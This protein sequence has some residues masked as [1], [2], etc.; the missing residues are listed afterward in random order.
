MSTTIKTCWN[1]HGRAV[2]F[3]LVSTKLWQI[4][5]KKRV[6]IGVLCAAELSVVVWHMPLCPCVH[7][8]SPESV[9]RHSR[10]VCAESLLR[11][12]EY[13]TAVSY[14]AKQYT[15]PSNYDP[16]M[17]RARKNC[18]ARAVIFASRSSACV[19]T[20]AVMCNSACLTSPYAPPPESSGYFVLMSTKPLVNTGKRFKRVRS[21]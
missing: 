6:R 4:V 7:T 14:C 21:H 11:V 20:R 16:P 12:G 2:R 18:T 5:A 13:K 8:R 17:V 1:T 9:G 19:R 3:Q 10:T 15:E